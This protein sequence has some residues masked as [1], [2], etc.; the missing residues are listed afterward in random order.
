MEIFKRKED[1]VDYI[2]Y[3]QNMSLFNINNKNLQIQ[4]LNANNSHIVCQML[5]NV[6]KVWQLYTTEYIVGGNSLLT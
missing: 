6:I 3:I 2:T 5:F 4:L 1:T